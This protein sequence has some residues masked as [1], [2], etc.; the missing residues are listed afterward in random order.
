MQI[1]Q[2]STQCSGPLWGLETRMI[3]HQFD[4][5]KYIWVSNQT[6]KI[7]IITYPQS[8]MFV[9]CGTQ[10]TWI[11]TLISAWS[12][13]NCRNSLPS[14]YLFQPPSHVFPSWISLKFVTRSLIG[15]KPA[16]VQAMDWLV[17]EMCTHSVV[18]IS[19]AHKRLKTKTKTPF[20]ICYKL[21]L[22]QN[23]SWIIYMVI[24]VRNFCSPKCLQCKLDLSTC[25]LCG[26]ARIQILIIL[27]LFILIASWYMVSLPIRTD[28][29]YKRF[30]NRPLVRNMI[31]WH[32]C[33]CLAIT[34][35]ALEVCHSI[36][37]N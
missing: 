32:K 31:K 33:P 4:T 14:C 26:N 29:S 7:A 19:Q 34:W 9:I 12:Q 10:L 2:A 37:W 30:T 25:A 11:K 18:C 21:R 6:T 27:K 8:L 22:L 24:E 23:S 35:W 20:L 28:L 3:D 16:L 5:T 1:H 17:R 13:D 36:K 15:K